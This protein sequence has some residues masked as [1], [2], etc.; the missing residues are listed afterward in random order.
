M[1]N[2]HKPHSYALGLMPL[3]PSGN[4]YLRPDSCL[5]TVAA[6]RGAVPCSCGGY[7]ATSARVRA[8]VGYMKKRGAPADEMQYFESA[9]RLIRE[10]SLKV[11]VNLTPDS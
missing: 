9:R 6:P 10:G 7:F 11:F 5:F 3:R 4:F 1:H 2:M 8:H